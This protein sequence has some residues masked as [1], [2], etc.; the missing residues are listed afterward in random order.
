MKKF[1]VIGETCEDVFIYGK[2]KRLS[3]EAPVPVF[4]PTN[5]VRSLG[6]AG[7]VC[8]NIIAISE[9][10][11]NNTSI[12]IFSKLSVNKNTK[13]RY[14][15]EKSNHY[16]LR[17]DEGDTTHNELDLTKIVYENIK[18]ADCIVISD[19]N[20]GFLNETDIVIINNIRKEK[21]LL[22]MDSKRLVTQKM[23][24][25]VDFFKMNESEYQANA[26]NLGLEVIEKYLDK[27]IISKGEKGA[28]HN[29]VN[30]K[31]KSHTASDV[32]G[33]GDTFFAALSVLLTF[34]FTIKQSINKANKYAGEV[35][36]KKGVT[37]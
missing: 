36:L 31:V 26:D 1:V 7:N 32:S 5:T 21:S 24:Q 17:V 11:S 33:A 8:W 19:Y 29:K 9:K 37:I 28:T 27:I 23:L 20:K 22:L 16:F 4:L 14:V 10:V 6:M 25:I 2:V 3:P 12:D 35:V 30:Y 18:A 13:T 34:G 15:D